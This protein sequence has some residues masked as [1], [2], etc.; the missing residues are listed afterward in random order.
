MRFFATL[1]LTLLPA[2]AAC[3]QDAR[4][5]ASASPKP[6]AAVLGEP[7][8]AGAPVALADVAKNPQAFT[9]R[10][11]VTTGTVT[12][13]CQHLGC[14]MEIRD[15]DGNA[16][17]RMHGHA[18]FVPR[19]ASGKHAKVQATLVPS[20]DSKECEQGGAPGGLAKLQLDATGVELD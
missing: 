20:E 19:T 1:A 6:L 8:A 12:A 18:F 14:W 5:S 11:F 2:L 17:V 15:A 3:S 16:H 4:P 9:G 10:S 13:V 7:I